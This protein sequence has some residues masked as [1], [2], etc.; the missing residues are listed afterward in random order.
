MYICPNITSVSYTMSK[1]QLLA[2][3]SSSFSLEV[4]IT[5]NNWV[6][7]YDASTVYVGSLITKS[8]LYEITGYSG[9]T[10]PVGFLKNDKTISLCQH[11]KV[12]L[13]QVEKIDAATY[14]VYKFPI[15][16]LPCQKVY[17]WNSGPSV[18]ML[19]ASNL[20]QI[21]SLDVLY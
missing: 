21:F 1:C 3:T 20:L 8:V 17:L 9:I 19:V 12:V 6:T 16:T 5:N 4:R 10:G 18:K 7:F 14:G 2:S 15:K 13:G 11:G